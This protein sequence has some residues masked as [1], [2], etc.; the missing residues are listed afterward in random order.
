MWAENSA[1]FFSVHRGRIIAWLPAFVHLVGLA[2]RWM[3]NNT[4]L[5]KLAFVLVY[6]WHIV[7]NFIIKTKKNNYILSA[8]M[9]VFDDISDVMSIFR[10]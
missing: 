3:E 4:K 1:V 7:I 10:R 2:I 5:M 8:G 6:L 9:F